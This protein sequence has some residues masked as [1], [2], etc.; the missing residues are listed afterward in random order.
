LR[1]GDFDIEVVGQ[2]DDETQIEMEERSTHRGR[3]HQR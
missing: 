3:F 1:K 2:E